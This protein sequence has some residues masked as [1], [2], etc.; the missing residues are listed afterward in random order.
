L[1]KVK[2]SLDYTVDFNKGALISDLQKFN[3]AFGETIVRA[4]TPKIYEFAR[5]EMSGYYGEYYPDYYERTYQ[6]QDHSYKKFM[7]KRGNT[8]EGG[9]YFD[10]GFT[11]HEDADISEASIFENVWDLGIH[12]YRKKRG[13]GRDNHEWEAI[14]GEPNR[15]AKIADIVE[16]AKFQDDLFNIGMEA[17]MSQKYSILRFR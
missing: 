15:F 11:F 14:Q 6:M 17:A 7:I 13:A 4:A 9:L 3:K 12:G 8:Y 1:G 5:K 2:L 16:S 10:P